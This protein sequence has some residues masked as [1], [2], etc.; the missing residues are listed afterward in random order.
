METFG[1]A[2]LVRERRRQGLIVWDAG[3][4]EN[5][6]PA[7]DALIEL[8]KFHQDKK[9]YAPL[10]G[11]QGLEEQIEQI[12]CPN[13]NPP[14]KVL[15]G[16]GLT[17]LLF[18]V[19]MA[20]RGTIVHI[21]PSLVSYYKQLACLQKVER[22]VEIPTTFET[23]WKVTSQQLEM[24]FERIE[25]PIMLIFNNPN[26]P[27]S[28]VYRREEVRELAKSCKRYKVLVLADEIYANLAYN[29]TSMAE[30]MP[31]VQGSS[32]SKDISAAGYRLGWLTFPNKYKEFAERCQN[33]A[34]TMYSC[35]S[36]PIQ[37]ALRDFMALPR[38]YTL[39]CHKMRDRFHIVCQNA[40]NR[41]RDSELHFVDTMAAWYVFVSF[42]AYADNLKLINVHSSQD[43]CTVILDEVGIVTV[44]GDSFRCC[45]PL[46]LRFSLI[47][48]DEIDKGISRLIIWLKNL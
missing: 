16:N 9:E 45:E 17:E 42:R 1:K 3:L 35:P 37:Y 6:C 8:I 23:G 39:S 32:I 24:A 14:G 44:D 41:L 27:T 26:N 2:A 48:F 5:K 7:P 36:T 30:F 12:R 15:F 38:A 20:F 46:C 31:C 25:G 4:G 33:F 18:V 28:V 19:Q 34:A 10:T 40:C 22:L 29:F 47:D 13:C 21:T 43:L 11:V